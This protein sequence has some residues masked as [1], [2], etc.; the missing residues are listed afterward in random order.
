[1]KNIIIFLA[2]SAAS[3][4]SFNSYSLAPI[5]SLSTVE[6]NQGIKKNFHALSKIVSAKIVSEIS[7][8][9]M[10]RSQEISPKLKEVLFSIYADSDLAKEMAG[11]LALK[12]LLFLVQEGIIDV[13][14]AIA[15]QPDMSDKQIF[16]RLLDEKDIAYPDY[17]KVY[18]TFKAAVAESEPVKKALKVRIVPL[19]IKRLTKLELRLRIRAI[20]NG[21]RLIVKS[22]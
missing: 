16:C 9:K 7:G 12:D 20:V 21:S 11:Y 13:K 18:L 1:M 17:G 14:A 4:V 22:A 3:S 10:S 15:S 8:K 19:N 5:R 6:L 2:V